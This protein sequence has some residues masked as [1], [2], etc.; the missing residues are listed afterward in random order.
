MKKLIKTVLLTAIIAVVMAVPCFAGDFATEEATG[1]TG[2]VESV[3]GWMTD[4][5]ASV[6]ATVVTGIS[7]GFCLGGGVSNRKT[8]KKVEN[9]STGLTC[10]ATTIN[11]NAVE[12]ATKVKTE[13]VSMVGV[14]K[15]EV[16]KITETVLAKAD[17]IVEA[18]KDHTLEIKALRRETKANSYLLR[19]MIKDSRMTQLR[20]DEI[21]RGYKDI[22]EGGE[23]IDERDQA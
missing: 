10:A 16:K 15:T 19:E 9:N 4:N 1:L 17:E 23:E 8:R 20:K 12:L 11:N 21:E 7:G 18:I 14:V 5:P 22:A 2:A 3:L 6:F 13:V